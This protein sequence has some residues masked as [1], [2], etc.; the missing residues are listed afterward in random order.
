MKRS[1]V[2]LV[3]AL[4]LVLGTIATTASAD[5]DLSTKPVTDGHYF[6][7]NALNQP[8]VNVQMYGWIEPATIKP[9]YN[10]S[11][12]DS[13]NGATWNK[14]VAQDVKTVLPVCKGASS[15]MCISDLQYAVD[16]KWSVPVQL[17]SPGQPFFAY[18]GRDTYVH[19][20]LFPANAGNGMVAGS[21]PNLWDLPGAEH[22]LGSNY[23]IN[24]VTHG[25]LGSDGKIKIDGIDFDAWGAKTSPA[26]SQKDCA[27]YFVGTNEKAGNG[28]CNEI[29]SMPE[30]VSFRISVRLGARIK[31]LKGWFDG[32]M[33][34]PEI[35]FGS[36][37][38]GVITVEGSP[39]VVPTMVSKPHPTST[40]PN[41][42]LG[43]GVGCWGSFNV[44][45]DGMWG[46]NKYSNVVAERSI[47]DN[48]Y[49]RLSSWV[50]ANTKGN[51][52]FTSRGV[53]G[54]ML[55]NAT[56]YNPDAPSWNAKAQSLSF[57]VASSHLDVNGNVNKGFYSLLVSETVAKCL[58]GKNI[59]RASASISV[60]STK[61]ETQTATTSFRVK[62][63]WARFEAANY[64]YSAPR[65]V[66]KLSGGK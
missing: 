55:T 5:D 32:R 23:W 9:H 10:T 46:Y 28:Y 1:L 58:W 56:T 15:T 6:T 31:E 20:G 27:A 43:G 3:L 13:R 37:S 21:L 61:G 63:G 53:I 4:L 51:A 40:C 52:C 7:M 34:N 54:V 29:V 44:R 38:P 36:T 19:T 41:S 16:G 57:D 12:F 35:D 42:N 60:T 65:I 45:K 39:I 17:T 49:F 30:N 26:A 33:A 2:S 14:Q 66:T 47:A 50:D 22:S 48:T 8:P 24:A 25:T 11:P 62:R 64:H 59:S 18:G